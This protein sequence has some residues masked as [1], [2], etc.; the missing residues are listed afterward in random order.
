MTEIDKTERL[1]VLPHVSEILAELKRRGRDRRDYQPSGARAA[2][3]R[4]AGDGGARVASRSRC[5]AVDGVAVGARQIREP[6]DK[7][8]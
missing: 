2:A 7:P 1:E 6:E 5:H 8:R 4:K 3:S